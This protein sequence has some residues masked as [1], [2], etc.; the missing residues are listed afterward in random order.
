MHNNNYIRDQGVKTANLHSPHYGRFEFPRMSKL[1][2]GKLYMEGL[3]CMKRNWGCI[4]KQ[5]AFEDLDHIS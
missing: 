3:T 5:N 2:H 4:N 1:L